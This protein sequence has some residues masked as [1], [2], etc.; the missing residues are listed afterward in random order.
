MRQLNSETLDLI[1]SYEGWYAQAYKDPVGIWTIGYGH[2]DMAGPPK[3]TPNL[4]LTREEGEDLLRKDLKK[5]QNA[6]DRLV[7]VPLNDNQYGAL[8]SFTFNLGEGNLSKSTLLKKVNAGDFRGA[9]NEFL[10]WN[11]AGGK[12]LNGLTRRREAERVLFLKQPLKDT[13]KPVE[14][15]SQVPATEVAK[16]PIASPEAPVRTKF[17]LAEFLSAIFKILRG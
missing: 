17:N 10:K 1:K 8:T 14:S 11:R 3:V 2:T 9:A 15:V 16:K 6:V 7:K 5:Y 13:Q 4:V 12:V